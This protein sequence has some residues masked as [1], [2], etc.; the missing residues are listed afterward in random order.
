MRALHGNCLDGHLV[1][2][3][4]LTLIGRLADETRFSV[5]GSH[6]QFG[7]GTLA[8]AIENQLIRGRSSCR[9]QKPVQVHMNWTGQVDYI[10][11]DWCNKVKAKDKEQRTTVQVKIP[12]DSFIGFVLSG[13]VLYRHRENSIRY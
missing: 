13:A 7:S 3:T 10:S 6:L 9:G 4:D 1:T 2:L 11:L 8:G 12:Y 5:R